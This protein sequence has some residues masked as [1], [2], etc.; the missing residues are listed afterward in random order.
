MRLGEKFKHEFKWHLL[1]AFLMLT[2]CAIPS[3]KKVE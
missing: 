3:P 1:T 2:A